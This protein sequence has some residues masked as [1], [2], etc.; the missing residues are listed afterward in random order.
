MPPYSATYALL[1]HCARAECSDMH[2]HLLAQ[3]ANEIAEW[4]TLPARA[5]AHGLGPLLYVHLRSAGVQVPRTVGRRLKALYLRHRYANRVRARV[6]GQILSAYEAAGIQALVVKGGALSHLIYPEPGLRP[7][8]DLDL[9]VKKPEVEQ[10]RRVLVDLGFNAPLPHDEQFDKSLPTAILATEGIWVGVE[11]HYDLFEEDYPASMAMD[12]L[13]V[14][15]LPF[16]LEPG[17]STAYTLGYEDMLWHLCQHMAFHTTVFKSN[18]LIW[19]ADI[20]SV[21]ERFVAHIDWE[22]VQKQYTLILNTLSLLHFMTPLSEPLLSQAPIRLGRAP[23]GIGLQFQGWPRS[24]LAAQ[25]EKGHWR[26]LCD[27]LFPSEWWLRLRY[28][29]GSASS[30][31]WY[32]WVRHPFHIVGWV[33]HLLLGRIRDRLHK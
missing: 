4:Q 3:A 27:T 20:V 8:S 19:A 7:M 11:I 18:R 26:I 24:S 9:L 6:L 23:Q 30:L 25:R 2:Y 13:T 5:E 28:G 12:D 21:A 10:A 32:R 31:F 1:G 15:P 29:L 14:A 17:N 33:K 16:H 22:R